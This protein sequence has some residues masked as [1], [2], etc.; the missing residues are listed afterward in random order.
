MSDAVMPKSEG[1]AGVDD[2]AEAGGAL[3]GP[4]PERFADFRFVVA[5]LPGGIRAQ[6]VAKGR[7]FF[8][9]LG[10]LEDGGIAELHVKLDQHEAA[11]QEAL[12]NDLLLEKAAGRFVVRRIRIGR[13]EEEIGIG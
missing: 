8:G 1:E 10:L 13:V 7:G 9:G 11:E 5:E 4:V 12:A 6:G 3:G 2:V